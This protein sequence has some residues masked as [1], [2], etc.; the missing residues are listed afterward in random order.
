MT[1]RA[2]VVDHAWPDLAIE[3]EVLANAGIALVAADSG[4]EDELLRLAPEADA[5]MVNWL[6]VSRRVLLAA[7]RCRTVARFGVG[8]DNIDV[9]AATELG[10]PVSRV[11]SYCTDEVAEHTIALL[12][13]VRRRIVPFAA[14]TAAG[15]WNNTAFGPMHRLRGT[16]FGV[17]GWGA[18]GRAVT[19]LARGLGM[20]VEVWSRSRPPGGWPPGVREASSLLQLA[21]RVDHLSIHLPLTEQTRGLIGAEVLSAMRPTA[22]LLNTARGPIVD[23]AALADA[24]REERIAG[25]GIDVLDADPPTPGN[26]LIGLNGAVVTPH[27]AFNSVEALA[28]LRR[29][30]AANVVAV[31]DGG[32]PS[33][34]VNPEVFD[35]PALRVNARE[36]GW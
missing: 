33:D 34:I 17:A 14:Q 8:V 22:I 23:A 9:A 19:D 6:P 1:R 36:A 2:L 31:L 10:I 12:L 18:I 11:S 5:I 35:R 15:G 30:A 20:K 21:R 29:Q 13:A 26:P 3:R 32:R 27:A 4:T 24:I 16:V 7:T 25:A 28:V